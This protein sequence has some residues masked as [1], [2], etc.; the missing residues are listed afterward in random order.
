[1]EMATAIQT[2]IA[3][4]SRYAEPALAELCRRSLHRFV[5]EFWNTINRE[6]FHDNWHIRLICQEIE[7]LF[8]DVVHHRPKKYD[9][10]INVPFG[11]SKSTIVTKMLPAWAWTNAPQIGIITGSY[12]AELSLEHADQTRDVIQSS[13]FKCLFPERRLRP[14][15]NAKGEY[16]IQSLLGKGAWTNGGKRFSCSVGGGITGFHGSVL[17]LDDPLNPRQAEA[18]SGLERRAANDWTDKSFLTRKT[19]KDTVPLILIMQR[20]HQDDTTG[21]VLNRGVPVRHINLP[22]E[23]IPNHPHIK[24]SPPEWERFYT[25][26]LLDPVRLSRPALT[27]LKATLGT[28]GYSAQILQHPVPPEGGMFRPD[29]IKI[30]QG[31]SG[32]AVEQECWY[33]DKAGTAG[34]GAW[35]VGVLMAKS[36]NQAVPRFIIRKIVRGQWEAGQRESIIKAEAQLTGRNVAVVIEQEPGSGGKESAQSTIRNLAGIKCVA[37]RPSG[38]KALRADPFSVQVNVGNVGIVDGPWLAAYLDEMRFF[39]FSTYQDQVDASSGAFNYLAQVK[40]VGAW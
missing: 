22:G 39:P 32:G 26:G 40:R 17:I 27:D 18:A 13:K 6:S 21:H 23:L 9:L 38:D 29:N 36:R 34:G 31:L 7:A 30:V 37:D 3:R 33:W 24:V 12:K 10:V 28:Y 5:L 1:M 11:T 25:D 15:S 20:L 2:E 8:W 4:V 35:T 16:Q 19:D 14:D